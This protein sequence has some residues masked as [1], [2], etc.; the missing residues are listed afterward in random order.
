LKIEIDTLNSDID[1]LEYDVNIFE[2]VQVINYANL[3]NQITILAETIDENQTVLQI[4][5]KRIE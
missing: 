5:I 3:Q 4:S 2:Q 1:N